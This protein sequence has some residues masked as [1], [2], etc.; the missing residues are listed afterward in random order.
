LTVKEFVLCL[1]FFDVDLLTLEEITA[2][3]AVNAG[4]ED[5][6]VRRE[7]CMLVFR[8]MHGETKPHTHNRRT[9]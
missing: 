8:R 5:G 6:V 7:E 4:E 3:F 1:Q 2:L 9:D